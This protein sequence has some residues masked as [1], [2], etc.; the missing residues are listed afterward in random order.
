MLKSSEAINAIIDSS[1]IL[2]SLFGGV[3]GTYRALKSDAK[4]G[5]HGNWGSALKRGFSA[6]DDD[7][8]AITIGSGDDAWNLS[9]RKALGGLAGLGLGYRFLSGG[10]VYRD[11]NGNTDIA[12]I[13]F[14]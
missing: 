7:W 8:T 14:V 13:P 6:A 9:G 11:K 4:Q 1:T 2:D 10:G 5:V 3:R 12:G